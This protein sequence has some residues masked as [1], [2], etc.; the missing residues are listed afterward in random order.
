MLNLHDQSEAAPT[1]ASVSH[2]SIGWVAFFH[3]TPDFVLVNIVKQSTF[4]TFDPFFFWGPF[5]SQ[6]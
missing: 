4:L 6:L 5:I 2:S 1:N 3:P